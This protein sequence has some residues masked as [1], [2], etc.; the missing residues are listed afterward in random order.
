MSPVCRLKYFMIISVFL[1]N[2]LFQGNINNP[3]TAF[4]ILLSEGT[5]LQREIYTQT[6]R[7]ITLVCEI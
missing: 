2:K 4:R 3:I 1:G 5:Y 6:I 7:I